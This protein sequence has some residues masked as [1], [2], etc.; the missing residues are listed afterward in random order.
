METYQNAFD[1]FDRD[2][3]INQLLDVASSFPGSSSTNPPTF[4]DLFAGCGGLS[5]GFMK[6]GWQGLFAVEKNSMAFHTIEHNFLSKN[7]DYSYNWPTWLPK[8]NHSVQELL[9]NFHGDLEG[10]R[11]KVSLIMGG[12][13]CQGFSLAGLR[14]RKDRRNEMY[15][16]YIEMVKKVLP[17]LVLLENVQGIS[18]E[19]GKKLRALKK[20]KVGRRPIP[21]SDKIIA[22]LRAL[23]Y[24]VCA[25]K[26]RAVD[27]GVPQLR[28]RFFVVGV[29]VGAFGQNPI[30]PFHLLENSRKEFLSS[31]K[32]PT[33]RPVSV[34]EAISDLEKNETID[35]PDTKRFKHGL[36]GVANG[37]YQQLM[38]GKLPKGGV[39]DSH[40]FANHEP[41]IVKRFAGILESCRRGVQLNERD[42]ERFGLKKS[43]TVPLGSDQPSHTLTTL[44]DDILHY[45]EPRILTVREF[46]RLQSFPD[47]FQFKGKYTTGGPER[48]LQCPRYTQVGNA[49]PPLLAEAI[50]KT[51][52][53]ILGSARSLQSREGMDHKK[54]GKVAA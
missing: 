54:R 4:I 22:G 21:Y 20:I 26:V 2:S 8:T 40:R 46:A 3:S 12:P 35:S 10:L 39:P 14:R 30:S 6:A 52:S 47:W 43:C 48:K 18:F 24:A 49:V 38:R 36:Y 13:P 9:K 37:V 41:R 44:P 50:G 29:H 1:T 5:L 19:F 16:A 53:G 25:Q 34:S 23:G 11:G 42:R 32:L 28:P 15:K 27:Y 45:S 33:D 7:T 51:L 17:P 31:K